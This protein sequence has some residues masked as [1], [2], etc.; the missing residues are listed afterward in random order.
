MTQLAR[1]EQKLDYLLEHHGVRRNAVENLSNS[2]LRDYIDTRVSY[3]PDTGE[4]TWLKGHQRGNPVGRSELST[5]GFRLASIR[6]QDYSLAQ[7]A[8]L[9]HTGELVDTGF[10]ASNDNPEDLRINNL[11]PIG[12]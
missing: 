12:V 8:W 9:I 11:N 7:I 2:E 4:L 10:T 3:D 1:I 6:Q 5:D